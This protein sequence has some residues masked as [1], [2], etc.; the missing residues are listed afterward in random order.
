VA[1]VR[2]SEF[3]RLAGCSPAAVT[4]AVKSGALVAEDD[5]RIDIERPGNKFWLGMHQ[6]G[7]GS[8][9]RLWR[10]PQRPTT[11]RWTPSPGR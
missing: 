5:G 8:N 4:L 9:G 6:Q 3:A 7:F 10:W 11:R 2:K 1:T